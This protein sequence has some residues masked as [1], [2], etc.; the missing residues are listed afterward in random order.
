MNKHFF[1]ILTGSVLF[2]S[3]CKRN[4]LEGEG[5][6]GTINPTVTTFNAIDID[7]PLKTSV[8]IQEGAQPAVQIN[9]YEN[10]I[11][12]MKASVENNKLT[13]TTDLDDTWDIDCDGIT[14]QVTMPAIAALSLSGAADADLHGNI[15]GNSFKL[16]TSG[17]SKVTIDNINVDN[18]STDGSGAASIEVKAGNVKTATYDISG[19]GKIKAFPLQTMETSVSISGAGKGEVT[20]QQKLSADIS[21]AG[22]VKYK[23]HPAVTKDISGAGTV[24]DAN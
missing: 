3:S 12:H 7:L 14:V 10:V 5:T 6:T 22:S 9:G 8:T 19:A 17:A 16:E 11:K 2:I 20:A 21:G 13:L 1:V 24:A 18:F 15:T 4:I 23:G